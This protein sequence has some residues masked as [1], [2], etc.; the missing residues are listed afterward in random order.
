MTEKIYRRTNSLCPECLERIPAEVY[1]DAEKNWVMMKKECPKHGQFKDKISIYPEEYENTHEI[2]V[3][4]LSTSTKP[5][6]DTTIPI[7]KGCPF[8]CGLCENHK[9]APCICLIDVTNRCNLRCPVCFANAGATG[10]VVE[11]SFDDI[12]H[13]MEH[14]RN[15]K[16]VPPVLLQLSGGEP[17]LRND[18]LDIIRKGRELGFSDIMLTTNGVKM[19]KS[20][21]YCQDLLDA[22]LDAVYLSFAG[23]DPEVYKKI[24]GVDITKVKRQALENMRECGYRGVVIVPTIVKGVNDK[25]IANIMDICKDY[26]DITLGVL[27][28]PVSICGRIA[29]EDLMEMRYTSSDLKQDLNKYTATA[30]NPKGAMPYFYPLSLLSHFTRMITW[31]DDMPQTSFTS[32]ADCGFATIMII[33][34]DGT[35]H[36]IEEWIDVDGFIK[37]SNQC[38]D[39]VEK[40]QIPDKIPKITSFVQK[41]LGSDGHPNSGIASLPEVR[42]TLRWVSKTVDGAT[43]FAFKKAMKAY[44]LG[45]LA[46]YVRKPD[47]EFARKLFQL[48]GSPTVD[49]AWQFFAN[50]NRTDGKCAKL[51]SSMHFQDAYDFDTER[52]SH[53]LVH[54]GVMDPYDAEHKKVLEIP[55]C[56]MNTLHRERLEK[57][58]A[59]K[60]L[61]DKSN[62]QITTEINELLKDLETKK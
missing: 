14:F 38:W 24:Y 15:I 58:S 25:E 33:E 21:Q 5:T 18:L 16:P 19:A 30:E 3:R 55:F 56:A 59:R 29:F 45:G 53:C 36:G 52:V 37:W 46:R 42:Q 43:D 51:I 27:F 23:T 6:C 20:K 31:C 22:G 1:L 47:L 60:D 44:F 26:R 17:T 13:I 10:F 32:D 57:A 48:A 39:L 8:D 35:W 34:K 4:Q 40:K 62:E 54:Y 50:S 41:F 12:I 28:Q 9:S 7:Q 49:T 2:V 11:P 61:K